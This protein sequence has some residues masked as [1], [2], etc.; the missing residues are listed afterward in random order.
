[1]SIAKEPA[2]RDQKYLDVFVGQKR[3]AEAVLSDA[4]MTLGRWFSETAVQRGDAPFIRFEDET[5]S[6]RQV[7][8]LA[9]QIANWATQRGLTSGDCLS[10]ALENRPEYIATVIGMSKIGVSCALININLTGQLLEYSLKLM[11]PKCVLTSRSYID[12]IRSCKAV[13]DAE[14]YTLESLDVARITCSAPVPK[15]DVS[16]STDVCFIYTSGTTGQ[17]KCARMNSKRMIS[18]GLGTSLAMELGMQDR[19]YVV[20]PL[21]HA[22]ALSNVCAVIAAGACLVLRKKFS[23]SQFWAD[24]RAYE[25]THFLYIGDICKFLLNR[26]PEPFDAIPSLKAGIGNGLQESVWRTFQGRF[27]IPRIIEYYASTE[28]NVTLINLDN[29]P[30]IVGYI[31]PQLRDALGVRLLKYNVEEAALVRTAEGLC[32]E[33]V[34]GEPGELVGQ[35]EPGS[36]HQFYTDDAATEKKIVRNALAPGDAWFRTG[37]LLV[38]DDTGRFRFVDRLGE[39]FRWRGENVA[40]G[41]VEL[42]MS[43]VPGI[44]EACVYGVTVPGEAGRAGMAALVVNDHFNPDALPDFFTEKLP[45]YAQ[46][47][48]LRILPEIPKTSTFKPKKIALQELGFIPS[49]ASGSVLWLFDGAYRNFGP[50]EQNLL[51]NGEASID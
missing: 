28:S 32:V 41:D 13:A 22:A 25:A 10:L 42:V 50:S 37:D 9:N 45:K 49:D 20:L 43:K 15:E 26:H 29:E 39:T 4:S 19:H 33:C 17:P 47:R 34:A 27:K 18:G 38:C 23:A 46:P 51:I 3:Q 21:F 40:T 2:N 5:Y 30:G 48:F 6:Y 24:C 44:V 31:P 12:D 14:V 36:D 11:S 1:M 7:D 8:T 35:I 16:Q